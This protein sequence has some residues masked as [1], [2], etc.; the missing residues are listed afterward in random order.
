M[1]NHWR[2]ALMFDPPNGKLSGLE[3]RLQRCAKR[4][5][6]SV[7][8]AHVRLGVADMHPDLEFLRQ[9]GDVKL[10]TVDAAVEVSV[11]ASRVRELPRIAGSLRES[12]AGLCNLSTLEVMTGPIFPI[13]PVRD[14]GVFLS[15]AF[16]RYPGT[17]S[18]QFRSWWLHQHS[19]I[20]TPILGE[21]LLAYDQVHVDHSVSDA[22]AKAFGVEAVQ[23][24]AYD[25]LTWADRDAFLKSISDAAAMATIY[26]DEVGR[27][28]DPSRRSAIMR[29]LSY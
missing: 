19:K 18:E 15:L 22:A 2:L 13:V 28:D 1:S 7:G 10:H 20:A 17:T 16:R 4:I 6:D 25:N 9:H 5:V 24:D 27:I 11:A 3:D 23:Y 26:A 8:D 29:R 14:G 21:G 12:L